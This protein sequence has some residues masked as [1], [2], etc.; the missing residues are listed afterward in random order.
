MIWTS[1]VHP[2]RSPLY[3][4]VYTK[5]PRVSVCQPWPSFLFLIESIR[6]E[7]FRSISVSSEPCHVPIISYQPQSPTRQAPARTSE[8]A[9]Q[10]PHS[11]PSVLYACGSSHWEINEWLCC[12]SPGS[13]QKLFRESFF[14]TQLYPSENFQ[15]WDF[16]G[17]FSK[18]TFLILVNGISFLITW[19][20]CNTPLTVKILSFSCY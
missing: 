20:I 18:P 1:R 11:W 9:F 3:R 17:E 7:A 10:V 13:F 12:F 16:I 19:T 8:M 6:K 14:R 15:T 2:Q 5:G 4:D